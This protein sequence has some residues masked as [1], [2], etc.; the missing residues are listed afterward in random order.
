MQAPPVL[1]LG[2]LIKLLGLSKTRVR[3]LVASDGF[4]SPI[5]A[6][7][8]GKIWSTPEVIGFCERTGRAVHPVR[9]RPV[10]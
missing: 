1:A 2:E 6:L 9:A 4:P 10:G 8:V 3:Q 5:A 7:G